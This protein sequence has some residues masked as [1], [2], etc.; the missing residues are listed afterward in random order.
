MFLCKA[1]CRQTL[2]GR[3]IEITR[4]TGSY[5]KCRS[6]E[7]ISLQGAAGSDRG[8]QYMALTSSVWHCVVTHSAAGS[9]RGRQ[10]MA[11]TSQCMALCSH[12]QCCR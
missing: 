6:Q 12:T 9:D 4:H 8:R 3:H 7:N 1:T 10:Y 5:Q 2:K 11:L